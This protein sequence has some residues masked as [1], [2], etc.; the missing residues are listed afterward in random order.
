MKKIYF[1][2]HGEAEGNATGKAQDE[3]TPLTEQGHE[4]AKIV[5]DRVASLKI[6]KIM[7]SDMDRAKKTAGYIADK[8]DLPVEVSELFREW[9]TPSSVRGKLFDSDEYK[10]WTQSLKDNYH[11]SDW[12]YEDAENFSDLSK[13]VSAAAALLEADTTDSI[14]VVSHGKFLR[15]FLAYVLGQKSLQP[16]VQISFHTTVSVTNTG[17][18]VFTFDNDTWKLLTWNDQAHFADN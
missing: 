16:E 5:A 4:Q 2:R 18:S 9:M 15:L 7:S 17:I 3:H 10:K 6:D 11:N 1:V 14:L 12:R 8:L 13:R